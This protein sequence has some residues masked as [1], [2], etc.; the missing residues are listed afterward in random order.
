MT[1]EK[2]YDWL[3]NLSDKEVVKVVQ[4]VKQKIK[5]QKLK[6]NCTLHIM[7]FNLPSLE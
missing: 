1:D 2:T 4:E 6:L 5:E 7:L 3:A